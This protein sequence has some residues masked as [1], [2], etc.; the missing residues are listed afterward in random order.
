MVVP[1]HGA[2]DGGTYGEQLA[3]L[4]C[5]AGVPTTVTHAGRWFGRV[6]ELLPRYETDVR[7]LFPDV[8]V[9]NFGVTECQSKLLPTPVVRHLTTWL[10]TSRA[11]AVAYRHYVAPP[12][13]RVLRRYQRAVSGHD[14][15]THRLSPRRFLADTRRIIDMTRVE[16]GALVLLLDI[17]PPGPRVEY[18]LPGTIER[19][20]HYNRLLAEIA[21]GYDDGVR[22]VRASALL[23][24]LDAQLPD[25]LHRTPA[26]H[27]LTATA[28]R[29]EILSW[30][31]QPR[32]QA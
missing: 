27:A 25:G 7:N 32:D 20:A 15:F 21:D 17:D 10:R 4:L 22:L 3:T 16:T 26:G 12:I 28:I 31:A 9:L 30:M 24:D 13:W 2:R 19:V 5:D 11:T 23:T 1:E 6:N 29:D 14:R 18:W 8:L